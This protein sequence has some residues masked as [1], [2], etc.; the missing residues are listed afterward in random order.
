MVGEK[1]D[2]VGSVDNRPFTDYF[3]HFS[4]K[5]KKKN[6]KIVTCDTGH[7]TCDVKCDR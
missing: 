1:L 2:W 3:Q 6:R 5:Q 7:V 4:K